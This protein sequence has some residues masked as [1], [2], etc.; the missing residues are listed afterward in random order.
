MRPERQTSLS[1]LGL[2][3]TLAGLMVLAAVGWSAHNYQKRWNRLRGGVHKPRTDPDVIQ[4]RVR[5]DGH[6]QA[7]GWTY[8]LKGLRRYLAWRVSKSSRDGDG[9]LPLSVR[10]TAADDCSFR[11][12][13]RV[14]DLCEVQGIHKA[15]FVGEAE[16]YVVS[17]VDRLYDRRIE[18][19]LI[20]RSCFPECP[21]S[22]Y[23]LI[24]LRERSGRLI[25]QVNQ[26]RLPGIDALPNVLRQFQNALGLMRYRLW[27]RGDVP[28]RDVLKALAAFRQTGIQVIEIEPQL[29]VLGLES[30]AEKATPP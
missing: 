2:S 12:V 25:V 1:R 9:L 28:C 27:V 19:G 16:G 21:G 13:D 4:V 20:L 29:T 24:D 14:M 6:Y 5:R 8:D 26:H 30:L 15:H 10:F 3:V 23:I 7:G 18:K 11:Y 17:I 22:E